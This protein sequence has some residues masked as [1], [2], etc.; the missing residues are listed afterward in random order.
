MIRLL[1]VIAILLCISLPSRATQTIEDM[2]WIEKA[3]TCKNI[4]VPVVYRS[5][6]AYFLEV[7]SRYL[8]K[9]L[10]GL[11]LAA[12]CVESGFNPNAR[13]DFRKWD[14]ASNKSVECK[15]GQKRCHAKAIGAFQFWPW[16]DKY[17]DRNDMFASAEFWAQRVRIQVKQVHKHCRYYPYDYKR[18]GGMVYRIWSA[19]E[20]R[21]VRGPGKKR[22][23]ERT[24]HWKLWV[25]WR[26]EVHKK[27]GKTPTRVNGRR[28][29]PALNRYVMGM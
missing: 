21:A 22:C 14:N 15:E 3:L 17:I 16:A 13:G 20:A 6:L 1:A 12:A 2:E 5:T 27:I 25:K 23:R 11:S 7:E 28:V 18:A 8:P 29:R 19:A 9:E 10:K 4:T 26:A 24:L